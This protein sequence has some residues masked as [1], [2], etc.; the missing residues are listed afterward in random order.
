MDGADLRALG[1]LDPAVDAAT[2]RG[3]G[4]RVWLDQGYWLLLPLLVLAALAFRR[5][6]GVL[7]L[8]P[9]AIMFSWP[10]PAR[11]AEGSGEG[12]WWRRPDQQAQARIAQGVDAYR[13]G[14]FD[15]AAQDFGAAGARGAEA[16]Y[17]PGNALARQG[18][19]DKAIAAYDRALAQ[20]PGMEDAI[21]NRRVVEAARRRQPPQSGSGGQKRPQQGQGQP[22]PKDGPPQDSGQASPGKGGQPSPKDPPQ[23]D[24]A[25]QPDT[26]PPPQAEDAQA[27]ERQ[28]QADREQRER[29]QRALEQGHNPGPDRNSPPW[30]T[31]RRASSDRRA[32][33]GC[34]AC[35]TI[36]ADCCVPS[37]GSNTTVASRRADE[38]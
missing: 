2:G 20:S 8:L 4:Q 32:K 37:S 23:Q 18:H 38:P 5:G 26:Q 35:R 33:P 7:A 14:D 12:G 1:V 25:R 16:Q 22:S 27:R 24:G 36:R 6:A 10:T 31:R 30:R 19:Y 13:Q 3:T 9:L 29:M 11:A 15:S 17:N 28:E 34:G 21:A